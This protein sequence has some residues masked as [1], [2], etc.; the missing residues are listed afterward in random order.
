MCAID[1]DILSNRSNNRF[2]L[3][4]SQ[5]AVVLK[6]SRSET[7]YFNQETGERYYIPANARSSIDAELLK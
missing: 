5:M 7:G 4:W 6:K 2:K 3:Y 1:L